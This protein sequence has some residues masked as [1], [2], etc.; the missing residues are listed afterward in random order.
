MALG[1]IRELLLF[2]VI[3]IPMIE[4]KL[5]SDKPGYIHYKASTFALIL[6][7]GIR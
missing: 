5:I 3:N 6:F 7:S 1:P 4:R 2:T